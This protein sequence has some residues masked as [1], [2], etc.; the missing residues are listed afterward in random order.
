M[1]HF[2]LLYSGSMF[3][4]I[5]KVQFKC[6]HVIMHSNYE[7]IVYLYIMISWELNQMEFH[8]TDL[9]AE[10]PLHNWKSF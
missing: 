2:L 5:S 9:E 8:N 6:M 3:S 7:A 1:F 10:T 4:R